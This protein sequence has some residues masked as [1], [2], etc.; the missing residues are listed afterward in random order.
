MP[1]IPIK[2]RA[3]SASLMIA[4]D[5]DALYRTFADP[6]VLMSWLP[7]ENMTGR[8]LEYDFREGGRYRIELTYDD[9]ASAGVG[10][11]SRRTDITTGSFLALDAGKRI[12]QS[13]EFESADESF[14]GR[15][16][17]SWSFEAVPTGTLV[18]V[19][20]EGVPPGISR[21]DH[22]AGLRSS[23]ANLARCLG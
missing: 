19:T 7:P 20:A 21:E 10:K 5:S 16:L 18:T 9:T 4:H 23:L 11:S 15:M 13:V 22:D 14:A 12:V 8:V 3:D 2:G 17:M 6:G 1:H